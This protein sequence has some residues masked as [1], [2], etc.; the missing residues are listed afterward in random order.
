MDKF[1]IA[2]RLIVGALLLYMILPVLGIISTN[3]TR[4]KAHEKAEEN[5]GPYV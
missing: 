1:L 4:K 3:L 5:K 2:E